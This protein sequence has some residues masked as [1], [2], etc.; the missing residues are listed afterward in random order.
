MLNI[1]TL[2]WNGKD[3]L[4]KLAP[5]LID[6]LNG[7]KY[8]WLIKDNG[9]TDESINYINSLNNNNINIIKYGH[10][11]DNFSQGCNFL[12]KEA[13]CK[14]DDYVLLLNN[15]IV[16][17]N[18]DSIKNMIK[19]LESNK[20]IGVV[21]AKLLYD[22]KTTIQH[23]GVVFSSR[24][25]NLP[26]NYRRG[27]REEQM[28]CLNREFQSV[29]AA[30]ML[31]KSVYYENICD[32]NK[33]KLHGLCEDFFWCFEDVSACLSIKYDLNKKIVYCGDTSFFHEESASLKKNPV[34]KLFMEHNVKTFL[35]MWKGEYANDLEEYENNLNHNVIK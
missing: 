7:L 34:N 19:S 2:N 5:T 31:T 29:T 10:N 35:N 30:V 16:V 24:T 9:S 26:V 28:D 4:A 33:S 8:K 11:R 21:G 13:S 27:Y 17:D 3:K 32:T 12:F 25:N 20:D 23:A 18:I 15:D 22:D 6:S 1:L 14:D